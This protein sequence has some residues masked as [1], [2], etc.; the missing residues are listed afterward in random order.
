MSLRERLSVIKS[1]FVKDI[2]YN[3]MKKFIAK[4]EKRKKTNIEIPFSR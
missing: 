2:Q 1:T 4:H 3:A